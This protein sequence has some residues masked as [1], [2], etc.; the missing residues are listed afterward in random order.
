[1]EEMFF[2]P[3]A[4]GRRLL[5]FLHAPPGARDIGLIYCHPF[6]EEKNLSHAISVKAARAL[7][8]AGYAVFRFDFSGCGD[9]EADLAEVTVED[10]IGD[11]QAAAAEFRRRAGIARLGLWGLR[12][13]AIFGALALGP[14]ASFSLLWHPVSD[15][16][17]YMQ[18]FLRQRV[19]TDL[20]AGRA[21]VTVKALVQ[22]IEAGETVE[23]MGYPIAKALYA[24]FQ[25][26][27]RRAWADG[28]AGPAAVAC[29][30]SADTVPEPMARLA[31][32]F[33]A[34]FP[35]SRLLRVDEPSFWD[36]YW[37]WDSPELIK[38]SAEWIR[39]V[40]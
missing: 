8:A 11:C 5:G 37:T 21:G 10:W 3:G 4:K 30:G 33:A 13:G 9:S 34:R 24:G 39:S 17:V 22:A 19:S 14:Q 31:D 6:A 36:R 15:P 27:A 18:Q 28:L 20:A 35:Q 25:D 38:A 12:A 32:G 1:M 40:A 26:P 2:F 16:K 23:V 7:A 29:V